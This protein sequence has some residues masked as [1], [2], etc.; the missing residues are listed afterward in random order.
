MED[1]TIA[2]RIRDILIPREFTRLDGIID[3]VFST[4]T[5]VLDE[6][7]ASEEAEIDLDQQGETKPKFTPVKFHEACVARIE[8]YLARSLLR[9]SRAIFSSP[10]GETA[11]VCAVS[12]E[13]EGNDYWFAFHPH[14]QDA[15]EQAKEPYVAF[16]C[17][18]PD[19]LLLIPFL[20]FREWLDGMN[21]TRRGDRMYWHVSI[22]TEQGRLILHRRR[23]EERIDLTKYFLPKM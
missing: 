19:T 15:L 11:L 12:K 23:G 2:H 10:N 18:S 22:Y 7:A 3:L 16:G 14:Q 8:G 21:I 6:E 13:H 17:G 1:P 20:D 4:T 9:R 5:D